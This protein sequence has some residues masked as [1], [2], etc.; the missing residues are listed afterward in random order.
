M[1]R[2]KGCSKTADAPG[3][4][5]RGR[6]PSSPAREHMASAAFHPSHPSMAHSQ[7]EMPWFSGGQTPL[8]L[9]AHRPRQRYG[10]TPVLL[11]GKPRLRRAPV[12]EP[13]TPAVPHASSVLLCLIYLLK[14]WDRSS[15]WIV[16]SLTP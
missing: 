14:S 6:C 11:K 8:L 16:G 12:A 5:E 9:N 4:G 15:S 1:L 3:N 7:Q 2:W 10:N 13:L